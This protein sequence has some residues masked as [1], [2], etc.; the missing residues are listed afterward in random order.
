[1]YSEAKDIYEK[2]AKSN[3][4]EIHPHLLVILWVIP[5]DNP[6]KAVEAG[7]ADVAPPVRPLLSRTIQTPYVRL[8]KKFLRRDVY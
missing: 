2:A 7:E 5:A 6:T 4:K 3:K 8:F 1:M